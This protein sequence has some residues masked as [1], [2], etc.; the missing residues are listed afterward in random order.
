MTRDNSAELINERSRRPGVFKM[1]AIFVGTGLLL[2]VAGL[3]FLSFNATRPNN[4]GVRNG[5]L[6]ECADKPN[7]VSSF[8]ESQTQYM[9]PIPFDGGESATID[10]LRAIL[11]GMDGAR[12]VS[13]NETYLHCEFSTPLFGFVDDV[14]FLLDTE[15]S[16]IH[17]RSA[18]RVGYHDFGQNRARINE[19]RRQIAKA[20][21]EATVTTTPRP[22]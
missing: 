15:T 8:A 21:E 3:V 6:A 4:L 7:C 2:S 13:A 9:P 5:R 11:S 18:S 10:A 22:Q 1:L 14:E 20:V 16:V 19:I 12:V 17:F